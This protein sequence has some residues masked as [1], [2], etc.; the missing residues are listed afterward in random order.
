[1]SD[2]LVDLSQNPL[3]KQTVKNLGLPIPTP[4]KLARPRGPWVDR[5]LH[6]KVVVVRA[7]GELE[8]ALAETLTRAGANPHVIGERTEAWRAAGEAYGRPA[9]FFD[10]GEIPE[11]LRAAALVLDATGLANPADLRALYDFFHPWI[12]GLRSCG[13]IVVLGR[14][15]LELSE[16]LAAAAAGALEGFI[17]SVAKE[18]GRKGSTAHVVYVSQGAEPRVEPLLRF[19]LSDRAAF[20]SGQPW[21]VTKSAKLTPAPT[22]RVLD[23]KAALVTGAARGIGA[24]TAKLLADEGAHVICLDRPGDEAYA[25]KVAREIGGSTLMVD[26]TDP[27]A[28]EVIAREISARFGKLDVLVHNAGITRDKTLGRMKPEWWDMA[29]DVNLGAITR[30]NEVLLK[31]H[32]ASHGRVICLSSV[33]GLAGNVGQTNY[34]ASKAGLVGYVRAMA[35]SLAKRGV[36]INAVAPGFIETRLTAAIPVVTREV[37]RRLSALGQGGLPSDVGELISFLASPGAA[38]IT[39]QVMRACGGMFIG[40]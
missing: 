14:P 18:I 38:G 28:G 31:E 12:G 37:G 16:P 23:G 4:Q 32:I 20:L 40:A 36:T 8:G 25:S 33:A 30:I 19:L 39:G 35:P 2:L 27:E 10:V 21:Y 9:R 13:R 1:M 11:G 26:I 22:T 7:A 24:A 29:V 15:P 6:D 17:R 5:P 34:A 3:F